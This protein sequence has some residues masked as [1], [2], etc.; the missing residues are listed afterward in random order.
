MCFSLPWM[1]ERYSNRREDAKAFRTEIKE[2]LEEGRDI[3]KRRRSQMQE[4]KNKA[5]KYAHDI[6]SDTVDGED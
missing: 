2:M 4:I 5:V 1:L 3:A 6:G